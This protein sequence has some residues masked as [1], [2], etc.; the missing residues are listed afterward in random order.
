MLNKCQKGK[1]K[2]N[3]QVKYVKKSTSKKAQLVETTALHSRWGSGGTV[4]FRRVHGGAL[5]A[6]QGENGPGLFTCGGKNIF[7]HSYKN[8]FIHIFY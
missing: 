1:G 7:M 3:L 8:I 4:S 6:D 2:S 5:V